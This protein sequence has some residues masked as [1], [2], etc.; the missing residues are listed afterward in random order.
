MFN[1]VSHQR[2]QIKAIIRYCFTAPRMATLKKIVMNICEDEEKEEPQSLVAGG[3]VKWNS[4]FGKHFG[5][6]LNCYR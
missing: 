3:N 1:I 5:N 2:M 6:F 4:Q